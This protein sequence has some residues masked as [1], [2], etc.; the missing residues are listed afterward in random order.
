MGDIALLFMSPECVDTYAVEKDILNLECAGQVL[1]KLAG[2][3]I[4]AT[5]LFVKVPQIVKIYGA[6]S[7][8]GLAYISQL[9]EVTVA[10]SFFTY[11]YVSDFP[12]NLYGD[13]MVNYIQCLIVFTMCLYYEGKTSQAVLFVIS[14]TL[15]AAF[16][17][18]GAVPTEF[19]VVFNRCGFGL[20]M[21]GGV[22][23]IYTNYQAKSTGQISIAT[24]AMAFGLC[25]M[26]VLITLYETGD[27]GLVAQGAIACC[28][29]ATIILQ[30]K[31]YEET[32]PKDAK[33]E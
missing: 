31:I 22:S 21:F 25:F 9:I 17:C 1:S 24:M 20:G 19:L 8:E 5:S 32:Q 33:T 28:V 16:L 14:A 12:F 6:K 15:I 26:H 30:I 18:S 4:I 7:G 27:L 10:A 13:S 3:F 23:Q 29:M 11:C 2:Y